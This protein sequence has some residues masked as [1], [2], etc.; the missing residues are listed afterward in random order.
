MLAKP[1]TDAQIAEL[2]VKADSAK[3]VCSSL[4]DAALRDGGSDSVTVVVTRLLG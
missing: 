4:I 2:M 1:G 3:Q